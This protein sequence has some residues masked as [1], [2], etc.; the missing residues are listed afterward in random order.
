MEIFL[1]FRADR[2]LLALAAR[3]I[4]IGQQIIQKENQI[5]STL[6]DDVDA[7]A[8]Q[9]TA[10]DSLVVF[11]QGLKD[12]IAALPNLTAAQQAQI[13]DIFAGVTKNSAAITAAMSANVPLVIVP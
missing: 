2:T 11:I 1:T 9:T 8:A 3:L 12:Q 5:M 6:Q 13:D 4:D 10:I 7:I